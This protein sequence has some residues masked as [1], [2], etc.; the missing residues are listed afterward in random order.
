MKKEIENFIN[1]FSNDRKVLY[2]ALIE[3]KDWILDKYYIDLDFTPTIENG[4]E[5]YPS[6]FALLDGGV[7]LSPCISEDPNI[8]NL[9]SLTSYLNLFDKKHIPFKKGHFFVGLDFRKI[10][11][12]VYKELFPNFYYKFNEGE[13]IKTED[14]LINAYA[15]FMIGK[16]GEYV[17]L[18]PKDRL[19]NNVYPLEIA[20]EVI[21][22]KENLSASQIEALK[23]FASR[24]H[25][26]LKEVE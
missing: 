25:I 19:L 14:E 5:I 17:L 23:E 4:L 12:K 15:S 6:V 21:Y 26:T 2:S 7:Y 16:K 24:M 13:F 22:K 18:L 3:K 8:N 11:D 10:D 20:F 1:L 9:V